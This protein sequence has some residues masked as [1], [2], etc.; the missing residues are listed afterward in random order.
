MSRHAL[1]LQLAPTLLDL[2]RCEALTP[3]DSSRAGMWKWS[4]RCVWWCSLAAQSSRA[5][6]AYRSPPRPAFCS[7]SRL[8]FKFSASNFVIL[9][10]SQF[11]FLSFRVYFGP[12]WCVGKFGIRS[13]HRQCTNGKLRERA[14]QG[15]KDAAEKL[16]LSATAF[17]LSVSASWLSVANCKQLRNARLLLLLHSPRCT[18]GH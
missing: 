17:S 9:N 7:T 5:W 4:P 15:E 16:W 3:Q 18:N 13:S 8:L 12:K 1:R 6:C 10:Y 2:C 11:F 14:E